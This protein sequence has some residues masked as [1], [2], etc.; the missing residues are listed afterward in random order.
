MRSKDGTA[1][2]IGYSFLGEII[3]GADLNLGIRSPIN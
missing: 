1:H 3:S 2:T